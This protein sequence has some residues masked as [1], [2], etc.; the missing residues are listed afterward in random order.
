MRVIISRG[1]APRLQREAACPRL[2][3][4]VD[5]EGLLAW[6][7]RSLFPRWVQV[8]SQW[9]PSAPALFVPLLLALWR[10]GDPS[11]WLS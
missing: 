3:G 7:G 5:V 4:N 6:P 9:R 11:V 2:S 10:E 8:S 1:C